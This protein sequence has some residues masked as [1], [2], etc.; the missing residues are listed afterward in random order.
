MYNVKEMNYLIRCII[1]DFDDTLCNYQKAKT[2]AINEVNTTL[3]KLNV[4]LGIFWKTYDILEPKLFRKFLDG[5]IS[6]DEYRTRRYSDIFKDTI[7]NPNQI[8]LELNKI[9]MENAN[10]KIELFDDVKTILSLLREKAIMLVV[11]TN[12]PADG[13][14]DK[15]NT[16]GLETFIQKIY[17]GEEIGF[18]KPN[19]KSYTY[20]LKDLL[21]KSSEVIMVGDSI[22]DDYEGA[23][24]VGI[25]AVLIDRLNSHTNFQGRKIFNMVELMSLF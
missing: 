20:V 5:F 24:K 8:P 21:L 12:G 2:N 4:N 25:K 13:Q 16:L 3:K 6:R 17:I 14:R 1:F 15:Y 7:E 9:Y 22:K 19:C 11:L 10:K 23:E 18:A